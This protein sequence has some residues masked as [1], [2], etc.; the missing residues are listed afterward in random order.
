[1]AVALP[2]TNGSNAR[3]GGA[4]GSRTEEFTNFTTVVAQRQRRDG[5]VTEGILDE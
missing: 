1:M 2:S 5:Q 4:V 3:V